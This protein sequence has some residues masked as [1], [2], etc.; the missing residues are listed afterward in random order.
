MEDE[1]SNMNEVIYLLGK[2]NKTTHP[3]DYPENLA[4]FTTVVGGTHTDAHVVWQ[5]GSKASSGVKK[6]AE[7]GDTR[8]LLNESTRKNYLG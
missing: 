8:S 6:F 5:L 1:L 7:W 4:Q 2:W 3:N